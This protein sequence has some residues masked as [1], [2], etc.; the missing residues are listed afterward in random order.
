MKRAEA[1]SAVQPRR[2]VAHTRR[3]ATFLADR[4]FYFAA[5]RDWNPMA[6]TVLRTVK[7]GTVPFLVPP[8]AWEL[9]VL[10]ISVMEAMEENRCRTSPA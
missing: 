1:H 10:A 5:T 7:T 9:V 3:L 4:K 2:S 6:R 8:A